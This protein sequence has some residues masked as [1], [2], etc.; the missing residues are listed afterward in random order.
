LGAGQTIP[1][2]Y[3]TFP[4]IKDSPDEF[5]RQM[6]EA[7]LTARAMEAGETIRL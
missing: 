5:V 6:D 2:H 3:G 7:G 4:F 1:L